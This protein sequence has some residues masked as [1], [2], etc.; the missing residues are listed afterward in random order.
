MAIPGNILS[1]LMPVF[2][3]G[4]KDDYGKDSV[5]PLPL[6]IDRASEG[7]FPNSTARLLQF[8][9]EIISHILGYVP[10]DSLANLALVNGDCRQLARSRQFTCVHLDYSNKSLALIDHLHAEGLKREAI[11]DEPAG[12]AIGACIRRITVATHPGWVSHRHGIA[13][14]EDFLA[15][16]ESV[17]DQSLAIASKAFFEFYIPSILRILANPRILPHLE[18]LDWEDMI[19]LPRSFFNNLTCATSQHLKLFRAGIEEDSSVEPARKSVAQRWPLRTLHLEIQ[20][21]FDKRNEI[22]TSLTCSSILHLCSSTLESLV[23]TSV[24]IDKKEIHTFGNDSSHLAPRFENLRVLKLGVHWHMDSLMWG[25]LVR[26]GLTVLRADT[27][28]DAT[29]I[30]YF[31]DRGTIPS[32]KTF[33]WTTPRIS[34]DH[35]LGFLG[36]NTQLQHLSFTY[37]VS[38]QLLKKRLLP[39]LSKSF[40]Y[41]TTLSLLW[42]DTS[43][44]SSS[45]E[46]ISRLKGLRQLHLSAGEQ[47]GWKHDWL[48]NHET[49]RCYVGQLT[50]LR[51]LALSRDSYVVEPLGERG[52]HVDLYS[53]YYDLRSVPGKYWDLRHGA[54]ER[55]WERIHKG[56]I[57]GEANKYMRMLPDLEWLYFGQ[58]PMG[59]TYSARKQRKVVDP[60]SEGRDECWTFLQEMFNG[61]AD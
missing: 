6:S 34:A 46:V 55:V 11:R 51:K 49:M 25:A 12:C 2:S 4:G 15:L 17:R 21:S 43:I 5:P 35:S 47:Y 8:P 42:D 7:R 56:K 23:W 14:D 44:P 22:G 41:L 16:P 60:L 18:L 50:S 19:D 52:H 38:P 10:S 40:L 31:R 58:L 54:R 20:P 9:P 61:G 27:E 13:L 36:D 39:L 3:G 37:V 45:L 28:A 30:D 32:L 53:S 57:L 24:F 1:L 26:D 59:I 29:S 33:V 48:I